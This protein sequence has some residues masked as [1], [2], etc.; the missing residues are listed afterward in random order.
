MR[1]FEVISVIPRFLPYT[2]NNGRCPPLL[3]VL[4]FKAASFVENLRQAAFNHR[5][6]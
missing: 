2:M 3:F 5:K 1:D 4:V 6:K